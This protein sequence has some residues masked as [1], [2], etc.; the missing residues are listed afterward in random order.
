MKALSTRHWSDWIGTLAFT[1]IGVVLW[2]RAPEF[3]LLILPAI[4][5]ELLVASAS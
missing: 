5:Q 4:L 3:G 2:R 1:A